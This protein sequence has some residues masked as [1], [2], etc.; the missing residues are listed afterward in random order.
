MAAHTSSKLVKV[1]RFNKTKGS[2]PP[3]RP[4]R[5]KAGGWSLLNVQSERAI[6]TNYD[7]IR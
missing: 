1:V 2:E 3:V 6:D 5:Q 4:R 7:T